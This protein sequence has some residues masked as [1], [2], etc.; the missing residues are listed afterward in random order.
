ME[1]IFCRIQL[2]LCWISSHTHSIQLLQGLVTSLILRD[3]NFHIVFVDYYARFKLQCVH[4]SGIIVPVLLRME[5]TQIV[6]AVVKFS[7]YIDHG[8][9]MFPLEFG[10]SFLC[11]EA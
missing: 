2:N 11:S 5:F 3:Q 6:I 10:L 9:K 1:Q 7:S 4:E 8:R